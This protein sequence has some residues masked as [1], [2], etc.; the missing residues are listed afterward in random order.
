MLLNDREKAKNDED[1]PLDKNRVP[2]MV[3]L[4]NL[5]MVF[6]VLPM[7]IMLYQ[8]RNN[9][10]GFAVAGVVA[11]ALAFLIAWVIHRAYWW[12]LALITGIIALIM[13]IAVVMMITGYYDF[14]WLVN[15]LQ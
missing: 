13:I 3:F 5:V 12:S 6:T 2:M 11:S 7:V 1:S 10:I 15:S 4:F 8:K 14:N 9:A